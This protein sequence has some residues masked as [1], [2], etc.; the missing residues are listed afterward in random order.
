MSTIMSI[1]KMLDDPANRKET[2]GMTEDDTTDY[3]R[4]KLIS[5]VIPVVK[6]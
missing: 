6:T 3:W 4:D 1:I 5:L 2:N